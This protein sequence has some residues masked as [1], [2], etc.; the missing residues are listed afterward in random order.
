[1][2]LCPSGEIRWWI[3]LTE[4]LF[5]RLL[6]FSFL[7][8]LSHAMGNPTHQV[9]GILGGSVLFP[10]N[11]S[12][13]IT[14]EKMEWDFLPQRGGLGFWLGEFSHGKLEQQ[15]PSDRFGQRLDMVDETTLRI[16]DLELDD[17]GIY[18]ARIWLT[19]SQFQE[20]SF[21]LTVYEPVPTPQI[22]FQEVSQTSE[23]CNVTLQCQAPR[24]EEFSISWK[25]GNPPRALG[26]SLYEYQ[27]SD[28]GRNL[29]VFWRKD[30][31]DSAFTC[32]LT[33]SVDQKNASFD[34]LKICPG[35]Q[36]RR[37]RHIIIS[38]AVVMLLIMMVAAVMWMWMR[39]KRKFKKKERDI[40]SLILEDLE[41]SSAHRNSARNP[42]QDGD[43]QVFWDRTEVTASSPPLWKSCP[44]VCSDSV[45]DPES[46]GNEAKDLEEKAPFLKMVLEIPLRDHQGREPPKTPPGHQYWWYQTYP[47]T[48]QCWQRRQDSIV[49]LT[50]QGSK[51]PTKY[52]KV[53]SIT[54][55][56]AYARG[57]MCRPPPSLGWQ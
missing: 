8:T 54:K 41:S 56:A 32:L 36:V 19:K 38:T 50:G 25:R 40:H 33:N 31:S 18:N 42:Q 43:N 55:E 22:H 30:S 9:K 28:S 52:I 29:C 21:S 39:R 5:F 15:S 7:D 49:E 10:V 45:S 16:K 13:G 26:N 24:K 47:K 57:Q 17:G 46:S 11:I 23:G 14:V 27:L 53:I 51:L 20:Q 2:A 44:S 1:M 48:K 4:D 6:L 12:Q 35:V 37:Q 3:F 34:L